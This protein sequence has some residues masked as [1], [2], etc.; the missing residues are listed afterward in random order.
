MMMLRVIAAVL[1]LWAAYLASFV[2]QYPSVNNGLIAVG[3]AVTAV[4]LW[5]R[6][7]WSQYLVYATS[8]G[9]VA[10]WLV[11]MRALIAIGW[12]YVE[13]SRSFISLMIIC[14]PLMFGV[15]IGIHVFRTFRRKT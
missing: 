6:K 5:F 2:V 12:P 3:L 7:P 10:F 14:V 4:G 9:L 1:M 11:Q 8:L 15:C 13:H